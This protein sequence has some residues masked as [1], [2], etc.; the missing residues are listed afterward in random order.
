MLQDGNK[1][2]DLFSEFPKINI[3]FLQSEM[4]EDKISFF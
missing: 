3:L 4:Q 1:F 2:S